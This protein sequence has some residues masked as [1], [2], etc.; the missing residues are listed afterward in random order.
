[1]EAYEKFVGA[2]IDGR[3]KIDKII[4]VGGMAVVYRAYDG[5][6]KRT[7]AVKMLK[8]EI[9]NDEESVRRFINE[10]KAVAM[11]SHPNIVN[12]YDVSVREDLKYIV[13]EY[14]EG[15]TLKN[16]MTKRGALTLREIISYTEQILTAL[17]H[18]HSKGIVHRDIKPQNIML[19]K[20]GIVKVTDFGI[21]KLPNAETVTLTD[22]AIGT[23]Y[24]ISPEQASGQEIDQ[25]SDLYSLGVM[26]YEMATGVLPFTADSP[27]SVA[28][29]QINDIAK[30]LLELN[31]NI[32][33][34]LEQI[35]GIAME[36]DPAYRYQNAEDMLRQI[37]RLKENP[38]VIFRIPKRREED[39]EE[40]KS[41]LALLFSGCPIFPVIAA[42]ALS[43]F[44]LLTISAAYILNRVVDATSK[45]TGTTITVDN[46]VGSYYTSQLEAWFASSDVYDLTV[47]YAYTEGYD[48]GQII[49][50]H[51]EAD[52]SRKVV[53]GEQYCEITLTVCRGMREIDIP[54]LAGLDYREAKQK[55]KQADLLYQT[56]YIQDDIYMSGQVVR[57]SPD[58]GEKINTGETVTVYISAGPKDG[59]IEVPDFTGMTEKEALSELVALSLRPGKITYVADKAQR[60]TII[61]QSDAKDSRVSPSTKINLTVSGGADFDPDNP[62]KDPAET[63]KPEDTKPPETT[64]ETTGPV[65]SD[66]KQDTT[67][68]TT[69]P[70]NADTT[71][72]DDSTNESDTSDSKKWDWN[73]FMPAGRN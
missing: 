55:L 9:A 49:E 2:V 56:E 69:D 3:Y 30:P 36:K 44:I 8:D 70:D 41:G 57:T 11:M 32:P 72:T 38:N 54:S 37:R 40:G 34:G 43:F 67:G 31:S 33:K 15:I 52:S 50:Q 18:A 10:S 61:A 39:G 25:R 16:Y 66:T 27:V 62:D 1:M 64:A 59:E 12:I 23:V 13:M 73:D 6:M 51:P 24:Y 46:F 60:G 17:R 35:I 7:V 48:P 5:L 63:T 68:D 26:M 14:V 47:E 45:S 4:G 22:K 21:A 28:M 58:Y 53:R 65:T 42:V 19:L 29:M 20:D 71:G